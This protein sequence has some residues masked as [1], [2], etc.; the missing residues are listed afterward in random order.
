MNFRILLCLIVLLPGS[1]KE[2]S[3]CLKSTGKMIREYRTLAPFSSFAVTDNIDVILS[4]GAVPSIEIEA[5]EN[6]LDYITT[7]VNNY[8][9]VISNKNK[10]NWLRSYDKRIKVYITQPSLIEIYNLSHGIIS[11]TDQLVFDSLILHNYGNGQLNLN[12]RCKK[13]NIDTNHFGDVTFTGEATEVNAICYRLARL[14]TRNLKCRDVNIRA[15]GEGD[16]FVNAE[17][18]LT[19]V[20]TNT[21]N[22][23]YTGN[24]VTVNLRDEGKGDFIRQ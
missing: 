7:E 17:N 23:Y 15:A 5:G 24:P 3:N 10:C 6:L 11:N 1:C 12:I 20:L 9:L 4:P 13:L 2:K 21:G 14:D 18:S 22:V 8:H 16:V 19:G